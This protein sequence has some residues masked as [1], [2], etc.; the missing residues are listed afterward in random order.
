MRQRSVG[1]LLCAVV[2]VFNQPIVAWAQDAGP[3]P[4]TTEQ[5]SGMLVALDG[6]TPFAQRVVRVIDA[7]TG[8]LVAETT[9][10]QDGRFNLP[11]LSPGEYRIVVGQLVS[12]LVVTAEKPVRDLRIMARVDQLAGEEIPL[13][14][15]QR[16]EGVTVTA[17]TLLLV[18]GS[19]LV[20]GAIAAGGAAL[21]YNLRKTTGGNIYIVPQQPAV[22]PA[23]P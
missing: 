1:A 2:A 3:A 18:G 7:G 15:L 10:G 17:G 19:V 21:G 13:A 8:K 11:T 4:V 5:V 16:V 23:L 9:T 14:D 20:I 22:S 6:K 12:R